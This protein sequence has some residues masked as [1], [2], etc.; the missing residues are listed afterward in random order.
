MFKIRDNNCKPLRKYFFYLEIKWVEK[1][2]K[3]WLRINFR[4]KKA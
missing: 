1:T 3:G 2:E 4:V